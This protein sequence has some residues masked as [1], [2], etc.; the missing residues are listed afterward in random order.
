MTIITTTIHMPP[1]ECPVCGKAF[2]GRVTRS[3]AET[4]RDKFPCGCQVRYEFVP[5]PQMVVEKMG[6]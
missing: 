3:I 5:G 1:Q 6:S 4:T 2:D